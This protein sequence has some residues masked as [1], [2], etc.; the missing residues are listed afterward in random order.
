MSHFVITGAQGGLTQGLPPN[1]LEINDLIKNQDQFSLYIQALSKPLSGCTHHPTG[2]LTPKQ[3]R[4]KKHPNPT[5]FLTLVLAEY[6]VSLSSSGRVPVA[7]PAL[8]EPRVD[9]ALMAL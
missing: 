4:C 1:R 3:L 9:I 2:S 7:P 6:T 5:R 8:Q